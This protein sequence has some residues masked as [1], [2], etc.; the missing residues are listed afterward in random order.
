M[1]PRTA[2]GLERPSGS[3]T[4]T[5][6]VPPPS[7]GNSTRLLTPPSSGRPTYHRAQALTKGRSDQGRLWGKAP[8]RGITAFAPETPRRG[9]RVTARALPATTKGSPGSFVS[10]EVP[11][12]HAQSPRRNRG[13][14]AGRRHRPAGRQPG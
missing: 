12:N 8:V 6:T 13:R 10:L 5:T 3:S 2:S 1:S 11:A 7:R 14:T 9:T 4:S